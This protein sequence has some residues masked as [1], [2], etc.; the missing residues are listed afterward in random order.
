MTRFWE[1]FGIH[2]GGALPDSQ[3]SGGRFQDGGGQRF[4]GVETPGRGMDLCSDLLRMYVSMSV[5]LVLRL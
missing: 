3:D 4:R 2:G 5:F 1:N